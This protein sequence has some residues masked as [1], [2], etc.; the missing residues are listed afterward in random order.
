[1]SVGFAAA[2][3]SGDCGCG[4][5]CSSKTVGSLAA[6]NG[7]SIVIVL[8]PTLATSILLPRAYTASIERSG[9]LDVRSPRRGKSDGGPLLYTSG[10]ARD[11]QPGTGAGQDRIAPVEPASAP[12]RC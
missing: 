1:M 5:G 6:S 2:G 7:S 8:A 10:N 4:V 3:S 9:G 12:E 11:H